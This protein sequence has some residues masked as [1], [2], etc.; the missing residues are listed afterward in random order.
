MNK[1]VKD[2]R[3]RR[4]GGLAGKQPGVTLIEL[5][6]VVLVIGVLAAIAYPSYQRYVERA[7]RSAVQGQMMDLARA[8]EV[9]RSQ[10][11]TFSGAAVTLAPE[12]ANNP[13]YTATLP[14]LTGSTYV[15]LAAPRSVMAGTGALALDNRGRTCWNS[16]SD[17]SCDLD[18]PPATWAGD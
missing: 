1:A 13:H 11:F 7:N 4:S 10:N 17:A 18:N 6:L 12:L 5:L 3:S 8:L 2:A 14:T 16:G 9:Y 15:I